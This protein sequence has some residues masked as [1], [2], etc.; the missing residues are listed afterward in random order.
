MVRA[1]LLL[2]VLFSVATF[3]GK[4]AEYFQP[5]PAKAPVPKDNPMT[6]EKI[7]LGKQL[8][9]DPRL[10]KDG[11]ISCNSC[12]NVMG[13]GTDNK[14]F[15]AGVGSKLG[16][17][18]SPTVWNAAFQ[19]V[20]FW[21]GRAKDLEEQ[22]KGPLTNPIEMAMDSHDLAVERL[23]KIPDYVVS[24]E[25]VF[26]KSGLN[27]NN[28]AKAIAAFERTLITPNAP[29]DKYL[30]GDKKAMT[31]QAIKGMNLVIELNCVQCHNGKNLSGPDLPIGEASWQKFPLIPD[32]VYTPKYKLL[33]D[34]GR[35]E[36]TKDSE[37]DHYYRV[38]TWRNIALT[39]PYFHNGSVKTLEEAV[40]VMA[41]VQ[42]AKEV[43]DEQ[44]ADIVEFLKSATGEFP[45]IVMPRLPQTPGSSLI[46]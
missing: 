46:D 1:L 43:T 31:K 20:Q 29:L 11:T 15:S 21:D 44:V 35:A 12:H 10:S 7:E 41:K 23:R 2:Q 40:R 16:G 37:H 8:F 25:K 14:A 3:A 9:F 4:E 5:L 13:N 18:S 26:G 27:I 22:A 6:A 33:A 39:A 45:K 30:R 24:F 42:L 28:A 38:P 36:V 32:D 17:R 34:K 19:S